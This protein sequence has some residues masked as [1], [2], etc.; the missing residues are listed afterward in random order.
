MEQGMRRHNGALA[1]KNIFLRCLI[2][3]SKG[4][5]NHMQKATA[6]APV[7]VVEAWGF[8]GVTNAEL[9]SANCLL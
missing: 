6:L 7:C 8:I 3:R 4:E 1:E 2:V 9:P 5:D